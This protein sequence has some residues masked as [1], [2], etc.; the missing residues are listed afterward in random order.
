MRSRRSSRTRTLQRLANS[1]R[2]K[3]VV[4]GSTPSRCRTQTQLSTSGMSTKATRSSRGTRSPASS[5]PRVGWRWVLRGPRSRASASTFTR[6]PGVRFPRSS[7]SSPARTSTTC[8]SVPRL[9]SWTRASLGGSGCS[10]CSAASAAAFAAC[11]R[12]CRSRVRPTRRCHLPR[13]PPLRRLPRRCPTACVW[14]LRRRAISTP[15]T[16]S[17]GLWASSTTS[18]PPSWRTTSRSTATPSRSS[19]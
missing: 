6:Q 15:S 2:F 9:P 17:G 7:R 19:T 8:R 5:S 16:P 4:P 18:S 14:T 1:R 12:S 3:P 10:R 11:T 13:R